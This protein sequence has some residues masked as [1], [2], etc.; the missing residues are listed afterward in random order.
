MDNR[1]EEAG[2]EQSASVG[3]KLDEHLD[4]LQRGAELL[5]SLLKDR[6]PGLITWNIAI[7]DALAGISAIAT[8]KIDQ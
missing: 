8:G 4:R 5:V 3:R 6:H 7:A 1:E 2:A